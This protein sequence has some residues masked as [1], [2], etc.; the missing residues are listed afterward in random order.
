M[1]G[2]DISK[3][4]FIILKSKSSAVNPH[5]VAPVFTSQTQISTK[6]NNQY[7]TWVG[8]LQLWKRAVIGE[9]SL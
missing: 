1:V 2:R 8:I 7:I 6:A 5:I 9:L 3:K 4:F